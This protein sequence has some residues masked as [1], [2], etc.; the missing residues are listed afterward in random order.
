LVSKGTL[1]ECL[2]DFGAGPWF[3]GGPW[4]VASGEL[5][6]FWSGWVALQVLQTQVFFSGAGDWKFELLT[7]GIGMK[8][9]LS[10]QV[11][12]IFV[13]ASVKVV[14]IKPF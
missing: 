14:V 13:P 9:V 2:L 7:S 8:I 12:Y 4:M 3:Q 1:L 10:P 11:S 6:F 5:T